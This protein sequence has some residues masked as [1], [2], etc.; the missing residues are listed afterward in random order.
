MENWKFL[1]KVLLLAFITV[2]NVGL[3]GCQSAGAELSDKFDEETVKNEAMK[4]VELFNERDYEG[5]LETGDQRLKELI[6]AEQLA[7]KGNPYLDKKGDFQKIE[8]TVVLGSEDKAKESKLAVVVMV[9]V[10][11][12]GKLQFTITFN[13]AM[14]LTAFKIK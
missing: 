8:K 13:E 9:G 7:E 10:Y 6:T 4:K 12:K 5:L 11:E 3:T 1:V 2:W 14:E